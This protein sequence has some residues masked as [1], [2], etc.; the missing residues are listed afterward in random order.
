MSCTPDVILHELI[1]TDPLA[2]NVLPII[3]DARDRFL[4]KDG[5]ILPFQLEISLVACE[6]TFQKKER[7][8]LEEIRELSGLYGIRLDPLA[9]GLS[10]NSG[11]CF[12]AQQNGSNF[13]ILSK[14]A[15]IY[16]IDFRQDSGHD[17]YEEKEKI[18]ECTS[19]GHVSGFLTFFRARLNNDSWVCNSPLAHRQVGN[20]ASR[21][22]QKRSRCRREVGYKSVSL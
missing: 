10:S 22:F 12:R 16:D 21:S 1:G 14:E 8:P 7:H 20:Q 5:V 3:C 18:I 15:R 17:I 13:R 19:S 11:I 9:D 2:E 4:N 6:L